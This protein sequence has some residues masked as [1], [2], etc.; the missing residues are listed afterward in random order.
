M[1]LHFAAEI[2]DLDHHGAGG[3]VPLAPL[4]ERGLLVEVFKGHHRS[5]ELLLGGQVAQEQ[6]PFSRGDQ[7]GRFAVRTDRDASFRKVKLDG[8]FPYVGLC[9]ASLGNWPGERKCLFRATRYSW[10]VGG[11]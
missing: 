2:V 7:L 11:C 3:F 6:P 8:C 5:V 9:I 4:R 1:R 10:C